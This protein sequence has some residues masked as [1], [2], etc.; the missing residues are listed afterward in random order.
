MKHIF[1]II[2][3]RLTNALGY[4]L[5][6]LGQAPCYVSMYSGN[7][8]RDNLALSIIFVLGRFWKR[9]GIRGP[10]SLE[11]INMTLISIH[12]RFIVAILQIPIHW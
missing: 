4:R 9:V 8:I 5:G 1:V 2:R 7:G 10:C 12:I 6:S 11:S 3:P